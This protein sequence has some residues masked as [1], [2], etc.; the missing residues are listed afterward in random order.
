MDRVIRPVGGV[1][2]FQRIAD[3]AQHYAN[4]GIGL[5]IELRRLVEHVDADAVFLELVATA[6]QL[7]QYDILEQL[8]QARGT[9]ERAMAHHLF[10][11]LFN[12]LRGNRFA[13]C[14]HFH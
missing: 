11:S 14:H 4:R 10:E 8:A 3:P 1:V 9:G 13:A 7:T 6:L 2:E 12:F 5:G